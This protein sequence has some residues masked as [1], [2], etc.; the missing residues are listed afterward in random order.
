MN[1]SKILD[2]PSL[3]VKMDH[4]RSYVYD[5]CAGT[6]TN[7]CSGAFQGEMNSFSFHSGLPY[8]SHRATLQNLH[9]LMTLQLHCG[10]Y[11]HFPFFLP[12]LSFSLTASVGA[13]VNGHS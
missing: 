2:G 6:I 11:Q 4:W 8:N 13:D 5:A 7:H 1:S 12:F 9:M 3:L 10:L